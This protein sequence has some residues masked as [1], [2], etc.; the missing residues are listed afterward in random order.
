MQL[1]VYTPTLVEAQIA[2]CEM[3]ID[4]L[5]L[6][7]HAKWILPKCYLEDNTEQLQLSTL[8]QRHTWTKIMARRFCRAPLPVTI[9]LSRTRI[10]INV[11]LLLLF[12]IILLLSHG[13]HFTSQCNHLVILYYGNH[14]VIKWMRN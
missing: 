1:C 11:M 13:F 9:T 12:S 14:R 5:V 8:K 10:S 4:S 6:T 2:H 3:F 7:Q